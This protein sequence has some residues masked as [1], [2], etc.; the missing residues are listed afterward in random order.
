MLLFSVASPVMADPSDT[1]RVWVSYRDGGKSEV[2]KALSSSSTKIHYDFPDLGAYVVSLPAAALNG[3]LNNPWVI[4]V[5]EDAERYPISD[6]A[7]H[8][9]EE[10]LAVVDQLGQTVPYGIDMVQAR[11]VWDFDRDGVVDDGAPTGATRTLCIIDSGYY[12]DHEDLPYAVGGVSQ[13][14]DAWDRDG[15]GHGLACWRHDRG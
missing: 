1:V 10:A 14:D 11:D 6:M 7:G 4:E 9:T 12:E 13:V 5:E 2:F 8:V 15:F 3:I